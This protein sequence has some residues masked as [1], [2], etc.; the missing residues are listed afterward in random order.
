MPI[1][2]LLNGSC[3]E[4]LTCKKTHN[5]RRAKVVI[6]TQLVLVLLWPASELNNFGCGIRSKVECLL[7]VWQHFKL[8]VSAYIC[9]I[10]RTAE[11]SGLLPLTIGCAQLQRTNSATRLLSSSFV[12]Q[13]AALRYD[14]A[15]L[16]EPLAVLW[17][18][19]DKPIVQRDLLCPQPSNNV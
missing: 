14:S 2:H 12:A 10:L 18:G 3:M 17:N 9:S 19:R 8:F 6:A 4:E 16:S 15:V 5:L 7:A 13:T 1:N 11:V